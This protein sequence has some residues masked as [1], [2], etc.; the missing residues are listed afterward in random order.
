MDPYSAQRLGVGPALLWSPYKWAHA[1]PG[2]GACDLQTTLKHRKG[3]RL[4]SITPDLLSSG[5]GKRNVGW[6]VIER[7]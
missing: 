6:R 2:W 7:K 5:R 3:L 4:S 1:L